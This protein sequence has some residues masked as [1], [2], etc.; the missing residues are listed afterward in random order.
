MH[1]LVQNYD[2]ALRL[3]PNTSYASTPLNPPLVRGE[4]DPAPSPYQGEGW[5]GV[6][7]LVLLSGDWIPLSLP[8][9]IKTTFPSAN[10]ISLGGA[11]EASIWSIFYPIE[12]VDPGWSSIPYGRPLGNQ[13]MYVLNQALESCPVWVSGHIYIGGIGLAQGYWQNEEKTS[14][15]FIEHPETG[16]QLYRTGDL[17]RYL[18]DGTLEFLGRDDFQVK[19]NGYRIE[20]GEIEMVLN[21]HP[22]IKDVVVTAVGDN[23][24]QQR[25]VAYVVPTEDV[26][27]AD[28]SSADAVSKLEFK[29]QQAGIR[30]FE[31]SSNT[32]KI[33]L[34]KPELDD[35]AYIRRQ[36]HRRFLD[37]PV[38]LESF[39]QW[40]GSL[41]PRSLPASPLPKYR[42]ASAGSLYPV[43]TYVYIKPGRMTDLAPGYYYYHPVE[44]CLIQIRED[45]VG[46]LNGYGTNQEI[47]DQGAF[48][49]FLVGELEAIAPLYGD[50]SRDLCLLEAGYISQLLMETAPDYDLG[51][52]PI[53]ALEFEPFQQGFELSESHCLLHSFVGGAIDPAWSQQWQMHPPQSPLVKG[54]SSGPPPYQGGVRGGSSL[55]QA[56]T[57][58]PQSPYVLQTRSANAKGGSAFSNAQEQLREFLQQTL[59]SYMVPTHFV[60]IEALPLTPN[61]KVDR[62]ALPEPMSLMGQQSAEMVAPRTEIEEAIAHIWHQTLQWDDPISVHE[63]FFNLGGNSL[64]A[65]QVLA[66][67]RQAFPV[68]LSIR[69]FFE[70][71]TISDHAEMIQQLLDTNPNQSTNA[72]SE[73]ALEPIGRAPQRSDSVPDRPSSEPQIDLLPSDINLDELSEQ[74]MDAM[75]QQLLTDESLNQEGES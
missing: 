5:G 26:N 36:S 44:H 30:Q 6:L 53:G 55:S 31:S 51:L 75:L 11:T 4:T 19:V 8:K 18:P 43:Q 16:Q 49:V 14:T 72:S 67:L 45:S 15:S 17:G 12:T 61:G 21:R 24:Q 23:P 63:N 50:K 56:P 70:R 48:A 22:M 13:Q 52:C 25:L 54:R 57:H 40:L 59:P 65:T 3:S 34:S 73:A 29:L 69:Q 27:L 10:V 42:Y 9:Q 20:L 2:D 66:Q 35:E 32:T 39:S 58:P 68:E 1:L 38:G 74:D 41:M 64:S 47:F 62:K 28:N 7:R 71:A 46:S 60:L 33:Q 37:A